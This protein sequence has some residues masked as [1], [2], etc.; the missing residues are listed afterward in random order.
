MLNLSTPPAELITG[1]GYEAK[2]VPARC[3]QGFCCKVM[4]GYEDGWRTVLSIINPGRTTMD[5]LIKRVK[6]NY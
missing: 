2:I 6:E 5:A 4:V 3:R 1:Q